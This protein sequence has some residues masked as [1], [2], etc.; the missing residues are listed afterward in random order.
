MKKILFYFLLLLG[1]CTARETAGL[2]D[3]IEIFYGSG[4]PEGSVIAKPGALYARRDGGV[5]T[6]LYF[7]ET[8]TDT[9]TG[10]LP[11]TFSGS[12][13]STDL[14]VTGDG[15]A[16]YAPANAGI[17]LNK[18]VG[19]D[20][21]REIEIVTGA[22]VG[23]IDITS[24]GVDF[25]GRLIYTLSSDLWQFYTGGSANPLSFSNT[26]LTVNAASFSLNDSATAVNLTADNQAVSVTGRSF[27]RLTSDNATATNRTF[28]IANG[29]HGQL[30]TLQW[31]DATD[32]GELIDTGTA[33]LAGTWSPRNGD[34]LTLMIDTTSAVAREISRTGN[35][36]TSSTVASGS[37][38]SLTTA[39]TANVTNI[40]LTPGDW[41]ISGYVGF[42]LGSATTTN[43]KAG[44]TT[45]SATLGAEGTFS[46]N[47]MITTTLS[48]NYTQQVPIQQVS[49]T[50]T[51]TYYL[52]AQST[53]SAGTVAAY[54]TIRARRVR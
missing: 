47:P 49:V 54:G 7:K 6:S 10:W 22:T 50:A 17:Y 33:D 25:D 4:T 11:F 51:T 23:Y 45:T 1:T 14:R 5:G 24:A 40:S 28:T 30:V 3:P 13:L 16:G 44:A 15:S 20:N 32:A 36:Y 52:V 43:F 38:V 2:R 21:N 9:N 12:T 39:T 27:I 48:A 53:F 26:Y 18:G 19:G 31:V 34:T 37:A 42:T 29:I 8:G 35:D 41:D 46:E